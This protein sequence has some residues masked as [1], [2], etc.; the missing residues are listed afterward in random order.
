MLLLC[1]IL[2]FSMLQCL[3]VICCWRSPSFICLSA[4]SPDFSWQST[5]ELWVQVEPRQ[6]HQHESLHPECISPYAPA[7]TM[8]NFSLCHC[9]PCATPTAPPLHDTVL[10][11]RTEAEEQCQRTR[12]PL[13]HITWGRSFQ[14]AQLPSSC[15]RWEAACWRGPNT[16]YCYKKAGLQKMAGFALIALV[17]KAPFLA[18]ANVRSLASSHFRSQIWG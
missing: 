9:H 4:S 11:W 14:P 2:D 10:R 17:R 6:P 13:H 7:S 5:W 8:M 12:P 18:A 3:Q 15:D 16:H 1:T